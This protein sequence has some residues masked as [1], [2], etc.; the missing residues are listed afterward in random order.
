MRGDGKG[1]ELMTLSFRQIDLDRMRAAEPYTRGAMR[2]LHKVPQGC[3]IKFVMQGGR[4]FFF[5]GRDEQKMS[6]RWDGE[7][8][9]A[10]NATEK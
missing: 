10:I 5:A 8:W 3:V 6:H 7:K 9:E 4:P 1:A 2:M